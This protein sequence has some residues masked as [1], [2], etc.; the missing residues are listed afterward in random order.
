MKQKKLLIAIDTGKSATKVVTKIGD[1]IERFLFKNKVMEISDLGVDLVPNSYAVEYQNKSFLIGD[2]VAEN[3]CDFQVSKNTLNHQLCIYLS[4]CKVIE[5]TNAMAYGVPN[6]AIAINCPLNI[7]KNKTLKHEYLNFIQNNGN[8]I[9]IKVNNKVYIF[10][11]SSIVILPEAIGPLFVRS[12][13]FRNKKITLIDIGS[14]NINYCTYNKL[15]PEIDSMNIA[16]AGI[17]ILRAKIAEKLTSIFGILVSDSD[18]QEILNNDGYLYIAGIKKAESK[19]IIEKLI[20]LHVTEIFN[21]CRSRG[22][23]FNNST[24]FFVG[25][26]SLFLK[27]YILASYPLAV[28]EEDGQFS[29]CLSFFNILEVKSDED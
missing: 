24:I 9:S 18:V 10:K 21:F 13:D 14:L 23:T 3:S 2:M 22:L 6:V 8:I 15:V 4:I 16:N 20:N 11:I 19:E 25:G 1:N 7:Y 17:N 12:N 26:G 29:N 5:K 27:P 28:I